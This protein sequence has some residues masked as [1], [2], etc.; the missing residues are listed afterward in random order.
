[1]YG[2]KLFFDA[3]YNGFHC[4][5]SYGLKDKK[6]Y[7]LTKNGTAESPAY[8]EK[9][10]D[11]FYTSL[12]SYGFDI[13]RKPA[14]FDKFVLPEDKY[15]EPYF[16]GLN[17]K[18]VKE[19]NIADSFAL[20]IPKIRVPL[21][22]FDSAGNAG[23]G[24]LLSA[25]DALGNLSYMAEGVYDWHKQRLGY[26]INVSS[27]FLAPMNFYYAL[28]DYEG[29]EINTGIGYPLYRSLL[30]GFTSLYAG[31]SYRLFDY[32]YRDEFRP[33]VF[34]GFNFPNTDI[35][36]TLSAALEPDYEYDSFIRAG[37]FPSLNINQDL[38]DGMLSLSAGYVYDPDNNS[39]TFA[40]LRGY[41]SDMKGN[42][43]V[44]VFAEYTCVLFE[45]RKGLWNP[46]IY[47]EDAAV[48]LF[49]DSAFSQSETRASFGAELHLESFTFFTTPLD[50][51]FTGAYSIDEAIT[52]GFGIS[53]PG[54]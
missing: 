15:T 13:Y 21:I 31:L 8:S 3:D 51:K 1:M 41:S 12:N 17:V 47:F 54:L 48:T 5:Y 26:N 14:V 52:A 46:N 16:S 36:F 32:F 33:Y 6:F 29:P 9:T 24:L 4:A 10:G 53:V 7:R 39:D 25:E 2:D 23:T 19:G 50:I 43:G 44:K 18:G 45:I 30:P 42:T 35:G 11:I 27:K 37:I 22:Y 38:F 40:V 20:L 28:S 49:A 34:A